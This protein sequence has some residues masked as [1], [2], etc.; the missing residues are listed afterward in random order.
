MLFIAF[1][2]RYLQKYLL[3]TFEKDFVL[4]IWFEWKKGVK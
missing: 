4:G 1:V 2:Y 3:I